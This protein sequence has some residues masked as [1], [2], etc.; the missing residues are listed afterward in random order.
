MTLLIDRHSGTSLVTCPYPPRSVACR[1]G[2]PA[3]GAVDLRQLRPNP[4]RQ[5]PCCYRATG[6]VGRQ[7]GSSAAATFRPDP[8][9]L[10]TGDPCGIR[11]RDVHLESRAK[12]ALHVRI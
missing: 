7:P 10:T 1:K 2:W 6:G 12:M 5:Q 4:E 9:R 8:P 3:C 11:T